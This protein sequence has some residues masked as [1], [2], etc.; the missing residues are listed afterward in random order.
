MRTATRALIGAVAVALVAS[1]CGGGGG[2]SEESANSFSAHS[3]EPESLIPGNT[4]ESEGGKIS[5]LLF[6]ALTT[7]DPK[8]GESV[9]RVAESVEGSEDM[10]TWTIKV[11]DGMKFHNGEDVTAE[12]FV[13]A[14]NGTVYNALGNSYF[15]TDLLRVK[16]AADVAEQ[17]TKEMSGLETDGQTITME[18]DAANRSVPLIIAY[19]AFYPM[20][21]A[22]VEALAKGSKSAAYK[23]YQ[24]API[25]NGPYAMDGKWQHNE[26][27]KLKKYGAYKGDDEGKADAITFKIYS[28]PDT[29]Y[30]DVT[31]GNLDVDDNLPPAKLGT[32]PDEFGD[33]YADAPSSSF[34]SL[35]FPQ[36]EKAY[37]DVRVRQAFSM[38]IDREQIDK[39]I[40]SGTVDPAKSLVTPLIKLGTRDDPCGEPCT[41]NVTKAKQLLDEA[42]FDKSK[43][44]E[45]WFNTGVGNEDWINAVAGQLRK[46]LGI[47]VKPKGLAWAQYLDA[48]DKHK[49]NGPFRYAWIMDYPSPDNYLEPLYGT[50][51]SSNTTGYSNKKVDAALNKAKEQTSD[52]EAVKYYHQ[53]EDM[54]LKDLPVTPLW[55]GEEQAVVSDRVSSPTWDAHGYLQ[56][57]KVEVKEG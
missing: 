29:A 49:Q 31:A 41:F 57:E 9:N 35:A 26:Q 19:T 44:V 36:W 18:L 40:F 34:T 43:T 55:Y 21:E 3:G 47:K 32:A 37:Q 17:K 25:G 46:N 56:Y 16:G 24:D 1:A 54:I 50:N 13:G 20:P 4:N 38:A 30:N 22:G 12:S 53:A 6:S 5:S 11:K 15:F 33:R 7:T 23:K 27:I 8:T 52:D 28:N 45:L 48:T 39:K 10:K 2:G 42:G 51:G 14:W